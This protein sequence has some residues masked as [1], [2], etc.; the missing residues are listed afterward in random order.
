VLFAVGEE[1]FRGLRNTNKRLPGSASFF[2]ATRFI[3]SPPLVTESKRCE[4]DTVRREPEYWPSPASRLG[5]FRGQEAPHGLA[6]MT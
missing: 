6:S 4:A 2:S 5:Y 1:P 3:S